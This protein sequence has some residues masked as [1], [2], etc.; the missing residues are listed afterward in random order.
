MIFRFCLK[1]FSEICNANTGCAAGQVCTNSRCI[2]NGKFHVVIFVFIFRS[3]SQKKY[4]LQINVECRPSFANTT[5]L[6]CAKN[7]TSQRLDSQ[8]LAAKIWNKFALK[9]L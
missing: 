1:T 6:S 9:S 5:S 8:L 4:K 2:P 3:V 7:L